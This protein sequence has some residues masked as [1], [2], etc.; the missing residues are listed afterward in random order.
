MVCVIN[1]YTKGQHSQLIQA[2]H[3]ERKR[4]F[5]DLQKWNLPHDGRCEYDE[6]DTEHA[7]YLV[8]A[9]AAG[10]DHL[11]SLRLLRTDMPHLMSEVFPYLCERGV[12]RGSDIREI[13]RLCLS[14]RLRTGDRRRAR[15]TLVRAMVEYGL[16]TGISAYTAVC[17]MSFLSEVLAIGWDV[18][19]LGLP[20]MVDGKMLGAF[21]INLAPDTLSKMCDGWRCEQ[22]AL[23][24]PEFDSVTIN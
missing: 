16:M 3:A 24:L 1:R 14:P 18:D 8:L 11:A 19:P 21:Q 10:G 23:K 6:F 15:N 7:Q 2:M 12:P 5:I 17:E 13:T 4:V 20:Q 22:P 9:D